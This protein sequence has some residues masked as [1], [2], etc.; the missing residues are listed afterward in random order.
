[1][2]NLPL[3]P[4]RP[5]LAPRRLLVARRHLGR[6]AASRRAGASGADGHEPDRRDLTNPA[7]NATTSIVITGSTVTG[8]VTTRERS[9]GDAGRHQPAALAVT[10]STITGGLTGG[11]TNSGTINAGHF[12]FFIVGGNNISG[13][14]GN[15]GTIT[16]N[17]SGFGSGI[18]IDLST[19]TGGIANNGTI[20]VLVSA[21]PSVQANGR[22]VSSSSAFGIDVARGVS[23]SNGLTNTGVISVNVS[24]TSA[25]SG[26]ADGIFIRSST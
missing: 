4:A 17:A 15:T 25:G 24:G 20:A 9:P 19:I 16:I 5:H 22:H 12:G 1:M 11:I 26:L 7:G 13:G 6:G 3:D 2:P 21:T 10:N 23:L 14:I 18:G 8:A